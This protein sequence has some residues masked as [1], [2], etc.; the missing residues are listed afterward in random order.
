M[1]HSVF[2]YIVI[3][4]IVICTILCEEIRIPSFER[5]VA[6]ALQANVPECG[7]HHT[8]YIQPFKL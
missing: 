5:H 2:I 1:M 6:L 7:T 3:E 8:N 4:P